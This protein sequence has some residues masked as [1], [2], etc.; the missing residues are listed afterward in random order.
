VCRTI[1]G[2]TF[3][4][5]VFGVLTTVSY[6]QLDGL[7]R[8]DGGGDGTSWDDANNWEQ[9]LDPNGNPISGNPA[10]PPGPTTSAAI[11]LAGVVIDNTMAGQTA[12]DVHIGTADG[13][14]S[15]GA[16]GGDLTTR[17]FNVGSHAGGTNAG[18]FAVSNG[19]INIGDDLTIGNGSQGTMTM[20]GGVV[21]I[22][23]D[24]FFDLASDKGSSLTMTGGRINLVDRMQMG[25]NSHLLVDGG[26][27]IADD[28]FYVLDTATVT[29]ES[30][31]MATIDK[32]NMGGATP[33]GPARLLINGGIMRS[34]E[35]TDNPD[36]NF[37][38]PTRFM[39][40]IEINGSGKLQVEQATFTVAEALSLITAGRLTTS[41][42][43]PL[44]LGIQTVI[45]PE[46]FG[47]TNVSFTQVSVVP[48][49]ASC[50]LVILGGLVAWPRRRR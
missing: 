8:F 25:N 14:G 5:L 47:R 11:P 4:I 15:L 16:S 39:S 12:L 38:D 21:N 2:L 37:D 34:N 9:V 41:E 49:P 22:G 42:V 3:A 35:W 46:F 43:S 36:L 50:V 7:Y 33:T 26:E 1:V 44:K 27:I 30:G 24:F 48:E 10:T 19:T 32:L 23:D 18:S 40:V 45:V 20:S 13:A 31:L 28:D 17:D 29:I 6:G